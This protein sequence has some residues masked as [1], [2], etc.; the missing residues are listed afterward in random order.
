VALRTTRQAEDE[1]ALEVTL[2]RLHPG[3]IHNNRL[4]NAHEMRGIQHILQR[5]DGRSMAVRRFARVDDHVVAGCLDKVDG[6]GVQKHEPAPVLHKQS[7]AP[8]GGVR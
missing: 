7:V 6:P 8:L 3:D 2:D 5:R 4:V 1:G